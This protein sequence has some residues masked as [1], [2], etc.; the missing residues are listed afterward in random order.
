MKL[1][2]VENEWRVYG[3]EEKEC[4]EYE[5]EYPSYITWMF[6]QDIGIIYYA[7][8]ITSTLEEMLEWCRKN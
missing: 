8:N 6:E 7:D 5:L 1:V 3:L 4:R 2:Q